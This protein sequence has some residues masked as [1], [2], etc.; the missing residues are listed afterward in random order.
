MI[1]IILVDIVRQ[2]N[3]IHIQYHLILKYVTVL[4]ANVFIQEM[5]TLLAHRVR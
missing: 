1:S 4:A 2:A 3:V 5:I